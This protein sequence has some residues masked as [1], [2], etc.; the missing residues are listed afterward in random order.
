MTRQELLEAGYKRYLP[1]SLI[2]HWDEAYY[3]VFRGPKG[4]HLLQI[5]VRFW[6][7]SKY[8]ALQ[9]G[10]DADVQFTS[11]GGLTFDVGLHVG[12]DMT[13]PQVEGFYFRVYEVMRCSPYEEVGE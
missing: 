7:H 8:G 13:L 5:G 1:N 9:D 11:K 6:R 2:D 3:K 4:N 10:W 12:S